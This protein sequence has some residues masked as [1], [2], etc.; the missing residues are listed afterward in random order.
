MHIYQHLLATNFQDSLPSRKGRAD[1]SSSFVVIAGN[2]NSYQIPFSVDSI[3]NPLCISCAYMCCMRLH[4][5][6][7]CFYP[8]F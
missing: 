3:L 7:R 6:S 5:F 1:F 2:L 4:G 8:L